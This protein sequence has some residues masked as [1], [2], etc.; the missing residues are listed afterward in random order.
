MSTTRWHGRDLPLLERQ[1]IWDRDLNRPGYRLVTAKPHHL[2][3]EVFRAE[4]IKFLRHGIIAG[5]DYVPYE[6]CARVEVASGSTVA[7]TAAAF[8]PGSNS[9]S[10]AGSGA[11][12]LGSGGFWYVQRSLRIVLYGV[13]T[14]ASSTPGTWTQDWKVDTTAGGTTGNS[15]GISAASA[16]LATSITNG[17]WY[18]QGH[19]TCRAIGTSGTLWGQ[20]VAIP[21]A[22][23]MSATQ[24]PLLMPATAPATATVDT[25]QNS[26]I[27]FVSTLGSASD[28]MNITMG[29]W[30]VLN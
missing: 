14:T 5:G 10:L 20:A 25:T 22:S 1:C 9:V 21:S 3:G 8:L 28:N 15:L 7:G 24:V 18:L 11:S 4:Q 29:F 6:V 26:F 17:T 2:E 12:T 23:L 16:T 27:K 30:E 13:M 19:I